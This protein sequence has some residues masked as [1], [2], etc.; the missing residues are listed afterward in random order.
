[1][2]KNTNTI[3]QIHPLEGLGQIKFSMLRSDVDQFS[4][5]IGPVQI[6]RSDTA[7]SQKLDW[8]NC[9]KFFL[10]FL[11]LKIIKLFRTRSQSLVK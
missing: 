4:E 10:T 3:W 11:V 5:D 6:D 8:M 1:M 7:Q 2:S 9:T